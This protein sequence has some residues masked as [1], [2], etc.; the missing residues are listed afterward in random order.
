[1]DA[2]KFKPLTAPLAEGRITILSSLVD[3]RLR[4]PHAL[5]PG[6]LAGLRFGSEG[7]DPAEDPKPSVG[8]AASGLPGNGPP[9]P[10]RGPLKGLS[11]DGGREELVEF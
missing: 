4:P 1:M 6:L 3:Q 2:P 10:G 7:V 11:D 9:S 5:G 8:L